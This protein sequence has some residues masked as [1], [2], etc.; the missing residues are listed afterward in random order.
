[1]LLGYE[2]LLKDQ[3]IVFAVS[4]WTIKET[5]NKQEDWLELFYPS[6]SLFSFSVFM[7][8]IQLAIEL[9]NNGELGEK[10]VF[11]ENEGG[12]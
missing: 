8:Q 5:N 1:M 3:E 9:R 11:M 12:F 4:L 10:G 6:N 2:N 7:V